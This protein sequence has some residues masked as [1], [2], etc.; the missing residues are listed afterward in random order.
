MESLNFFF[1]KIFLK[2]ARGARG[3]GRGR[4]SST[5][6]PA[7][8]VAEALQQNLQTGGLKANSKYPGY[9]K[10]FET[11]VK[12]NCDP[13]FNLL[14]VSEETTGFIAGYIQY[15]RL[16]AI[17]KKRRLEICDWTDITIS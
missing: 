8:V 3:R 9:V 1:P 7:H 5:E 17:Q 12:E 14:E 16:L 4:T 10:L 11:W 13:N 15:R 2:M 6:I